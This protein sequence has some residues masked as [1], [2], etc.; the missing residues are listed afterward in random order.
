MK[1]AAIVSLAAALAAAAFAAQPPRPPSPVLRLGV[2]SFYNPRLMYIKYQPLIDYLNAHTDRRWELV[3]GPSYER[4]VDDLCSG[5]LTVAY[6]GPYTYERAHAR[7]G[8]LPVV[9][10][11]TGGKPTY[12]SLI[13]VR[14]DNPIKSLQELVGKRFGFGSPMSTSSHLMPRAMLDDAGLHPGADLACR[15]Y[16]HHERAARAVLLGEV[17]ACG[18]RDIVGEKFTHRG[19][20]ILATSEPMP[21]FPFVLAPNS[22]A[23]L[24]DEL[25]TT[26]VEQ[27]VVDPAT[28]AVITGWDE[29][30]SGGFVAASDAEYAPIRRLAIRVFGPRALTLGEAQL[31]CGPGKS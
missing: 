14:A 16:F 27:P 2:V 17:D 4:T 1:P 6:L 19:L 22:P 15:Y 26:L 30:L 12:R 18:V 23:A 25:F 11:N 28:A 8:A 13:M 31:E 9:K 10:L 3:I 5:V 21:N 7:C 20:R 29:E 24:R